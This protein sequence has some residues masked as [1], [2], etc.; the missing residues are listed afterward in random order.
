MKKELRDIL[1]KTYGGIENYIIKKPN[2]DVVFSLSFSEALNLGQAKSTP[3]F[4]CPKDE[5]PSEKPYDFILDDTRFMCPYFEG[6]TLL[7]NGMFAPSKN[8][9]IISGIL[10][11]EDLTLDY[12]VETLNPEIINEDPDL[13]SLDI[14]ADVTSMYTRGPITAFSEMEQGEE[15]VKK[16]MSEVFKDPKNSDKTEL[17]KF[18]FEELKFKYKAI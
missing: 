2:G 9:M 3:F 5:K 10:Y 8:G 4:L 14:Y 7:V 15:T 12:I 1:E 18:V 11:A 16:Y 6:D 13:A 17:S